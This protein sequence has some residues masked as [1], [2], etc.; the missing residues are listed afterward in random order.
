MRRASSF[1]SSDGELRSAVA[2]LCP[3]RGQARVR[4]KPPVTLR[5][6]DEDCT[7]DASCSHASPPSA[8]SGR[9]GGSPARTS[10]WAGAAFHGWKCARYRSVR[11]AHR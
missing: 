7:A 6:R 3:P 9:R 2:A 1:T 10:A 8:S 11:H 5:A 4:P